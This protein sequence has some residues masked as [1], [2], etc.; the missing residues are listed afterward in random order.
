VCVEGFIRKHNRKTK[1]RACTRRARAARMTNVSR[2]V[3]NDVLRC[4]ARCAEKQEALARL[5]AR[6]DEAAAVKQQAEDALR[7][8]EIDLCNLAASF[9]TAPMSGR[10]FVP[11]P[12]EY[13]SEAAARESRHAQMLGE[14]R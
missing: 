2:N 1:H 11:L 6:H 10:M 7:D 9:V 3:V 14:R 12:N 13:V 4:L 5:P 8:L